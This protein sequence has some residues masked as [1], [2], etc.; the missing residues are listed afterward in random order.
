MIRLITVFR[1]DI[2]ELLNWALKAN[3]IREVTQRFFFFFFTI[4][5]NGFG[6]C[7]H[8]CT[9]PPYQE[10][11]HATLGRQSRACAS[12]TEMFWKVSITG[13]IRHRSLCTHLHAG[14]LT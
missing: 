2:T 12:D 6:V 8:L 14:D 10:Q 3:Y 7:W 5:V 11:I 13:V 1:R 9:T 4:E